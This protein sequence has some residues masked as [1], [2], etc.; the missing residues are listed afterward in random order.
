MN[1]PV[2]KILSLFL[3]IVGM[4]IMAL[5]GRVTL[6][7]F[8]IWQMHRP[9]DDLIAIN[10]CIFLGLTFLT[11]LFMWVGRHWSAP[12]S[13]QTSRQEEEAIRELTRIQNRIEERL[14]NLETIL[15]GRAHE[16]VRTDKF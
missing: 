3:M 2:V 9:M 16:S 4:F 10:I 7:Y 1:N 11:L 6:H 15:L 13:S 8:G 12:P 14:T 5:M